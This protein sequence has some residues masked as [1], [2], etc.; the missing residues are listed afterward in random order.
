MVQI[1]YIRPHDHKIREYEKVNQFILFDL[2]NTVH[3]QG[4]PQW[5]RL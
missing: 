4:Y 5:M 2:Y 1:L 3:I